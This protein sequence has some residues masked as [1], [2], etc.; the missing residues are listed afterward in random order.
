MNYVT[1]VAD[2]D[3]PIV[4]VL[5]L[6]EPR[7]NTVPSHA[8]DKVFSGVL[9]TDRVFVT[10]RLKERIENGKKL[11]VIRYKRGFRK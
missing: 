11:I 1:S 7:Y 5:D 8:L 3:V 4:S 10:V 9:E 2:H 6:E